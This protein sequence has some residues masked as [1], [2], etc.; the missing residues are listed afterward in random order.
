MVEMM[1]ARKPLTNSTIAGEDRQRATIYMKDVAHVRDGF[2]P[3]TNVVCPTA[4]AACSWSIYKTGSASTLDIVDRVKKMLDYN[5]GSLPEGLDISTF[6]DQSLY[7][8]PSIQGVIRE[9]IIAACLTA[10]M[11]LLFSD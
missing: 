3:Q 10:I 11:I 8:P 1:A 5:K 9:A 2:S 4:S 7:G 6:F